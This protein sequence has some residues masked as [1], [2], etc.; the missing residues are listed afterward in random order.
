MKPAILILT[1]LTTLSC[2]SLSNI[3]WPQVA[4]CGKPAATDL[5]GIVG[6]VL[7]DGKDY[8]SR[9]TDLARRHGYE[10]VVCVVDQLRSKW[11]GS[12]AASHPMR[13]TAAA[14]ARAFLDDVGSQVVR[15]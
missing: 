10:T 5:I 7:L 3:D 13:I 11:T 6:E 9:L 15:E 12:A 2:T 1:I 8:K 14:R 4:K